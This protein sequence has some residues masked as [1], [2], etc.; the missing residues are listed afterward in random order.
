MLASA[1]SDS[2][3]SKSFFA[4]VCGEPVADVACN[5]GLDRTYLY[6]LFVKKEGVSPSEY[7]S[8]YR[9][10]KAE[11]MLK[12][13]SLSISE[14]SLL[15]GF[16]DTAYFYKVFTNKYKMTPKKYKEKFGVYV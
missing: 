11:E 10:E 14:V 1:E 13:K 3:C 15:V 7:L 2:D 6:R 12:D 9:M 5:V 8:N 16:K 4:N